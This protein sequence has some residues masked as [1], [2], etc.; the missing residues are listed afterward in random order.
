MLLC[1]PNTLHSFSRLL[2]PFFFFAT[3]PYQVLDFKFFA[4]GLIY[5]LAKNPQ[6]QNHQHFLPPLLS[7]RIFLML[8]LNHAWKVNVVSIESK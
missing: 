2:L 6:K 1:R 4:L 5:K 3:T 8:Y 7:E